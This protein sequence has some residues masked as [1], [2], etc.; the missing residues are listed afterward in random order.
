MKNKL[1]LGAILAVALASMGATRH[2]ATPLVLTHVYICQD[3]NLS[4][5]FNVEVTN[6]TP[7]GPGGIYIEKMLI[8]Q[9]AVERD[10]PTAFAFKGKVNAAPPNPIR[11]AIQLREKEVSVVNLSTNVST[12]VCH[13]KHQ[14]L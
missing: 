3:R 8:A 7:S 4:L 1:L 13:S 5:Q 14:Q 9:M 10:G 11:F 6:G 12:L 2:T